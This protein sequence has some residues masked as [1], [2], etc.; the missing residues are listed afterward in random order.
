MKGGKKG[1]CGKGDFLVALD[2]FDRPLN[3]CGTCLLHVQLKKNDAVWV[4][5]PYNDVG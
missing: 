5:D 1:L 4:M 3:V 2:T